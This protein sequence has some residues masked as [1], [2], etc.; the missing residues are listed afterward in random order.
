M[1]TEEEQ[2]WMMELA[3]EIGGKIERG[4]LPPKDENGFYIL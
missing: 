2:D 4:E 3:K 1:A